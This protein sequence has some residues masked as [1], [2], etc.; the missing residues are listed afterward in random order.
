MNS[1]TVQGDIKPAV[2]CILDH[3]LG[4]MIIH[5]SRTRVLHPRQGFEDLPEIIREEQI[6]DEFIKL[7]YLLMGRADVLSLPGSAISSVKKCLD[8]LSR[9]Q[10]RVMVVLGAF[11]WI[12]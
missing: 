2:L 6:L 8:A 10:P 12:L 1:D 7:I 4:N 11:W 5:Y 9:K 3:M